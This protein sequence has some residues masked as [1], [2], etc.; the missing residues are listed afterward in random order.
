VRLIIAGSRKYREAD[1]F[2]QLAEWEPWIRQATV[3]LSGDAI[4]PDEWGA[5][6]AGMLG[7]PVEHHPALWKAEGHA[8]GI[9]RNE[10][11][12]ARADSLLALWDGHSSGTRHMIAT[13]S[14]AGLTV[15]VLG[16]GGYLCPS[17]DPDVLSK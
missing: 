3:V 9:R 1:G 2:H 14:A 16:P 15:I 11:M 4:G 13:A 12:A 5:T 10:R 7:I 17:S 8:A 6:Y